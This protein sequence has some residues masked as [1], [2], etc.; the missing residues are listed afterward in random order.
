MQKEFNGKKKRIIK[1]LEKQQSKAFTSIAINLLLIPIFL[2]YFSDIANQYILNYNELSI[3]MRSI[4]IL[5]IVSISYGLYSL[6][7]LMNLERTLNNI[8]IDLQNVK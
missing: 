5:W 3:C 7:K 2:T 8:K 4:N 6:Y 1:K